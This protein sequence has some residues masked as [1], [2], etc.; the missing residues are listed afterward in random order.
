MHRTTLVINDVLWKKIR[1]AA[2][3]E[4]VSISEFVNRIIQRGLES[5]ENKNKK[6]TCLKWKSAKMGGLKIDITSRDGLYEFISRG[7]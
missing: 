6:T 2:A 4:D 1:K 7:F 3:N 5:T